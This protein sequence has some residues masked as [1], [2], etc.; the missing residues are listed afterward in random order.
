ML[1]YINNNINYSEPNML[2]YINN[3]YSEPNMLNYINNNINYK[4]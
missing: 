4:L 1:N 3:N 2:N